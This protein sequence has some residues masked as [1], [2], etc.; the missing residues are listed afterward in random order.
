MNII[1]M[2]KVKEENT[3]KGKV[4]KVNSRGFGFIE[5]ELEI[6]FFFHYTQFHGD[7]K[8]LLQKYVNGEVIQVEFDNNPDSTDGPQAVNVRL[9]NGNG[10]NQK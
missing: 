9:V 5:T 3:M 8:Q 6:D 4:K 1:H 2:A 10:G 7:W